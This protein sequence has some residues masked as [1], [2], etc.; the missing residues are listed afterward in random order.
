MVRGTNG[1]RREWNGPTQKIGENRETIDPRGVWDQDIPWV[2]SWGSSVISLLISRLSM[3]PSSVVVRGFFGS[4]L[5]LTNVGESG[6]PYGLRRPQNYWTEEVHCGK[7]D[8]GILQTYTIPRSIINVYVHTDYTQR[9]TDDIL[10][11]PLLIVKPLC[12]SWV[13]VP[14]WWE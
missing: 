4:Y 9:T 13:D 6:D 14:L 1:S 3:S 5:P 8:T 12:K 11:V 7:N 2:C 10:H